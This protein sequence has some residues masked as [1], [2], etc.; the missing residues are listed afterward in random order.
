MIKL[1]NIDLYKSI[2]Y[3]FILNSYWF[4]SQLE[5]PDVHSH[6]WGDSR[7]VWLCSKPGH[8]WTVWRT[9]KR[10]DVV[11]ILFFGGW[12]WATWYLDKV[13][14]RDFAEAAG[15]LEHGSW[16]LVFILFGCYRCLFQYWYIYIYIHIQFDNSINHISSQNSLVW[17]T[18][19]PSCC[20]WYRFF[21][22]TLFSLAVY[23]YIWIMDCSTSP[24]SGR[25]IYSDLKQP[26]GK[27]DFGSSNISIT[28]L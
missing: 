9:G 26:H 17:Y 22:D 16:E 3:I 4:D 2:Y 15:D 19:S 28:C 13:G 23:I 5:I 27:C 18:Q 14:T 6:P 11:R 7:D 21:L 25:I 8:V 12:P 1:N 20:L 24:A 10:F